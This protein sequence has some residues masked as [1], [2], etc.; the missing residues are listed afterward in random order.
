MTIVAYVFYFVLLIGV[1]VFVHEGGHFLVA[2]LFKVKVHVF[3]LGFGPRLLGFRGKETDYRVSAVPIGGYVKM[4]GEDPGEVVK[5]EDAGRAFTDKPRWQ[6]FCI[7][8][9]GPFMNLIFPLFLHFGVGLT[10]DRVAPPDVGFV[11]PGMPGAAAGLEPGDR[12]T[13]I[14]G[15]PVESFDEVVAIVSP[16]PGRALEIELVRDGRP[17]RRTITPSAVRRSVVVPSEKETVGQIG[18]YAAYVAPVVGID[19]PRSPAALAGLRTFDRIE[20]IDGARIER[21]ADASRAVAK[22]AGRTIEL[23]VRHLKPDAEAPFDDADYA[24]QPV[25][26][27][28]E[29]PYGAKGLARIGALEPGD[30]VAHVEPDGPAARI[31]LRRGDRLLT[32]DGDLEGA[33]QIERGLGAA[34]DICHALAWSRQGELFSR[35]Y[36]LTFVPA[37]KKKDLGV[38]QDAYVNGFSVHMPFVDSRIDNPARLSGAIRYAIAETREGMRLIAIGFKLLFRR[39]VSLESIGGPLMIG[40]LAGMAG[41][42]GAVPFIWMMALISLNLG[43]INL[44]PIPILDGGQILI[45]AVEAVIR[46]PLSRKLKERIM[47]VGLALLIALMLFATRNDI[48]RFITG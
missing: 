44:L 5:A 29:V 37:G 14:D 28:V 40:Q 16:Q 4:L 8:A 6:R 2:K 26:A 13:A 3:S 12:I 48:M 33:V 10:I 39:E 47:L 31:G 11:V 36:R 45:I 41:Q 21:F 18:V 24:A 15:E 25:I 22:A 43:I 7:I 20:A 30:F 42:E 35:P 19:D 38:A 1:L 9:A 34:P 27:R 17:I 46:R 23:A 32:L